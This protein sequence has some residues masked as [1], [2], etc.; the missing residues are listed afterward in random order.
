[1]Q[2]QICENKGFYLRVALLGPPGAGKSFSALKLGT[3][4]GFEKVGIIDTENKSA[5]RYA[6]S[7]SRRFMS[8]E[9]D[10]FSPADYIDAIK[11]AEKAGIEVLII[12]SLS[13]G[14]M[15]KGGV[16]EMVDQSAKR[17][18]RGGTPNNFTGWRDV[19]P[20]HNKLVDTMI[21]CQMHL[22]VTMRTKMEYVLEE[23]SRGKKVPRKVGLQPVQR[24][25]LEYEFDI[26]GDLSV[27]HVL[28]ITK[29]RCSEI[30][31]AVIEKP[32]ADLAKT[33]RAWVDGGGPV[34]PE[35]RTRDSRPDRLQP[36]P[37]HD[38]ATDDLDGEQGQEIRGE[39]HA[40]QLRPT[41]PP[42]PPPADLDA[43]TTYLADLDAIGK[44]GDAEKLAAFRARLN[45]EM[46]ASKRTR[47]QGE[48][49]RRAIESAAAA[50]AARAPAASSCDPGPAETSQ[51]TA[52]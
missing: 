30:A 28:A 2:F 39:R 38:G 51:E 43:I 1:M 20:E 31:D 14:W 34:E 17:Q 45:V 32:G 15:G 36:P 49:L 42:T 48:V 44:Y 16:L 11:A 26:I 5:R 13:H 23:D 40:A 52:A 22:I 47:A 6:R 46:P 7:F 4:L 33:L 27:D 25:G 8:L 12:D 35:D 18:A 3:E 10:R 19:T 41:P 21:R 50:I 9:L 29:S 37:R 24:D